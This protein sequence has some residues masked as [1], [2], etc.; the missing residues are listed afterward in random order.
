M[1]SQTFLAAAAGATL[2]ASSV[3][4][5]MVMNSPTPFGEDTLTN[6]PLED[7]GSDFPC[8]LRGS[9]TYDI[10]TMNEIPVGVPQELSFMGGA[11]HGGG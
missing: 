10:G 4:A 6:S 2:F 11:T 7:D 3:N 8:K 1:F 5:H 9:G